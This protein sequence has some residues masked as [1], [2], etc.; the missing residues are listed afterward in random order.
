[1]ETYSTSPRVG[2]SPAQDTETV[3][4]L[5][6][7]SDE[8][9]ARSAPAEVGS[10]YWTTA[11]ALMVADVVA[12][13]SV[14]GLLGLG[15][16]VL[17][18]VPDWAVYRLGAIA[19]PVLMGAYA[20][21]GLYRVVDVHPAEELRMMSTIALVLGAAAT[22]TAAFLAPAFV[23]LLAGAGL[24]AVLVVPPCRVL[25]R[26][27]LARTAWWGVPVVVLGADGHGKA[28][29][30]T[31]ERWPEL[32]FRPVALLQDERTAEHNGVPS[33]AGPD[34][35]PNIASACD[36]PY[37][38][39]AMPHLSF[40]MRA[41]MVAHYGKFFRRLFVVPEGM[42]PAACWTTRSSCQ[43]LLGF[44]VTHVQLSRG[45]RLVKRIIDVV[46]AA[47][48]LI[49]AAPLLGA[50]AVLIKWD[51][52]GPVFFTQRRIGEEGRCFTVI[53]F[54]TMYTNAEAKLQEILERD[55][56]RR[57]QYECYH[58]LED[59]PRVTPIGRWLRKMSLDELPQLWNV[60]RGDMSLVGPRAYMPR[61]LPKMNGL[62]RVV[63]QCPPGIT[64]LWQ[65]SGRNDLDFDT[66]VHLD[67]HYVQDWTL[68]LDF[69]ILLRTLPVVLTGEGAN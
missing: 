25:A 9:E 46:G 41:R 10:G 29:I 52:P 44:G 65:V 43:P 18:P 64:G 40:Q 50:I 6:S 21:A 67:V 15:T 16:S 53:K 47:L 34:F 12:I 68:W 62:S 59:D 37:A 60:L 55:P 61:E 14:S 63:A 11:L 1:M 57:R 45:G 13:A 51:S 28:V 24:L 22:A 23:P 19:A 31:L 36:I 38:V 32:G 66:R 2:V 4:R 39:I 20:V 56:A 3:A 35:A 42:G 27:L 26:I 17:S 69:Y 30:D 5:R 49:A 54:R 48:A 8:V 7:V 58:K 33:P